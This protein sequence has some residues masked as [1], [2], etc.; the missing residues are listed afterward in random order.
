[1][2]EFITYEKRDHIAYLT[3]NRP[4]VLNSVHPP[5]SQEMHEAWQDFDRD[6]DAW[7]AVFTGAGDRAF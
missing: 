4:A 3:I 5:A 6:D 1:M 2:P 7:I